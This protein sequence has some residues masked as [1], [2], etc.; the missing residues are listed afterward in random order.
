MY[1]IDELILLKGSLF[2]FDVLKGFFY[3]YVN[4]YFENVFY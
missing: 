3:L 2:G 1:I 4:L